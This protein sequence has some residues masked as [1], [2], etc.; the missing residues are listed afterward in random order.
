MDPLYQYDDMPGE[1]QRAVTN[2][3]SMIGSRLIMAAN[4]APYSSL[5]PY[6][7]TEVAI[8]YPSIPNL[9]SQVPTGKPRRLTATN[10][11][12]RAYTGHPSRRSSLNSQSSNLMPQNNLKL[13]QSSNPYVQLQAKSALA[14]A[15][16]DK[17][18]KLKMFAARRS[19]Q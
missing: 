1:Q 12:P 5:V 15:G 10:H 7:V 3:P 6:P 2:K 8:K 4:E 9:Q 16:G 13:H 17:I 14:N 11:A 19:K 18:A